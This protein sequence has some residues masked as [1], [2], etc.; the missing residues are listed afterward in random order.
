MQSPRW[1]AAEK[2]VLVELPLAAAPAKKRELHPS[3]IDQHLWPWVS[4]ALGGSPSDLLG[5]LLA[6]LG[7]LVTRVVAQ[8]VCQ[9]RV[10]DDPGT[11]P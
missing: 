4:T 5:N 8:A 7:A 1:P 2:V 10:E 3:R 9:H 11:S 6:A